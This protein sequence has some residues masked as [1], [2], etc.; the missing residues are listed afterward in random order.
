MY[1]IFGIPETTDAVNRDRFVRE[2]VHPEDLPRFTRELEESMRPGALFRGAYRIRRVNDGQWRWIQYYARFEFTPDDKP[3]RLV[4]VLEDITERK[5]AEQSLAHVASFPELNPNPIFETDLEGKVTYANPAAQKLFPGLLASCASNPLMRDWASVIAGFTTG[6]ETIVTREVEAEGSVFE[7]TIG[8]FPALGRVRAYSSDITERKRAEAELRKVNRTLEAMKNSNEAILR[9]TDEQP[10]LKEVC[11]IITRDCEHAM[12]WIGVAENN[13]GKIVRP[14][15]YSGF[16]EGYLETLR[17]TWDDSAQGRG[18]TG[19][20]IRTGQPSMCR[21]MLTD[22]A[23]APWRKEAIKRG[24][25]SSLVIPL[26]K[27]G[28]TWGAITIYSREPDAFTRSEVDLLMELARDLEFGIQTLRMRVARARAEDALRESEERLSLFVEYAPAALAMFDNQMRYLRVSQRWRADYGLGDRDL[29]GVSHYDVFPEIP[30][31][32]KEAHRKGLA[33]EVLRHEADRF[34]R[35]DGTVQWIR[36]EVRPWRDAKGMVGGILIFTEDMTEHI[37]AEE[38]LLRSEKEA[39]QRGQ[40]R[41][42]AEQMSQAREEERKRVARDLH[43]DIGQLLTAIKMDLMWTKR[44]LTGAEG[45][46][47]DRLTRSIEMIG[48]GARSVRNI[49]NG[50]RPGVLDDLGLPAAIEWQANEFA[51]RTGI[52]CKVI[53]PSTDLHIESGKSTAIFRIFQECLTNV[54]RHAE[55]K[56]VSVT[57]RGEDGNL[58]LIVQDDGVGFP[59]SHVS[60]SMG[61]LGL[62]GM[63]ERAQACG[64]EA[65]ITSSPGNGTTVAVRVPVDAVPVQ[66]EEK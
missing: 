36:W 16:E 55:A 12:V 21:N 3:L 26:K 2:T 29:Y 30:N 39:F 34:E 28:E 38:A 22:P 4:G 58:F 27:R 15:A 5:R 41:A 25:A 11:H 23:F 50:L 57:L 43:D 45:E 33:G 56:S 31:E 42:L 6:A 20:A 44:H 54:M 19:T 60:N 49:C 14:V 46:V 8:Y 65:I 51:S 62:L 32:W 17:V 48:N 40:L 64:G 18:P 24:Y 13:E 7:E 52:D 53:L 37:R 63:K 1:E 61:S 35:A 9:A 10:F 59:E 66:R 47:Q